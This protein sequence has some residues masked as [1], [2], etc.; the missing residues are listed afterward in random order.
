MDRCRI[1]NIIFTDNPNVQN[2]SHHANSD[3][4]FNLLSTSILKELPKYYVT[5]TNKTKS[6]TRVSLLSYC[7]LFQIYISLAKYSNMAIVN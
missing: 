4:A 5:K 2:N 7:K 3:L 1:F 6:H